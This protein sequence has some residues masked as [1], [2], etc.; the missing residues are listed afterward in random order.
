MRT[1]EITI[2]PEEY[3]S[4]DAKKINNLSGLVLGPTTTTAG[5]IKIAINIYL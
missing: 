4:N 2:F 3:G 1:F 5:G